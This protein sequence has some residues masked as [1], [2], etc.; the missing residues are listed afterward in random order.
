MTKRTLT[1]LGAVAAVSPSV[2]R[3]LA[4]VLLAFALGDSL[5]ACPL[6]LSSRPLT[7]SAQELAYAGRSV[8]AMP[9][10]EGK[11]FRVVEVIKGERP[12]GDVIVDAVFR[13]KKAAIASTK[14]LL[15]I[16]DDSW[17]RWVNFG[18][19]SADQVGWLRQLATTKRTTQ[20]DESEWR[21]HVAFFLPYL[22]NPEPMVAEIA[23]AELRNAPYAALR[24]LKPRLDIAAIR[25]WLGDPKLIPRRPL[26]TLLLGIGGGPEDAERVEQH[27]LAAHNTK[28]ATNLA[29]LLAAD[30]EL[31][32]PSRVAWIE[33]A[34]LLRNRQ[35]A[36]PEIEAALL[37]LSEQG[38][39][40]A[41]IPRERVVQ[42]Y[43]LFIRE[44]KTQAGLVAKDLA[45]WDCWDFSS[46]F[47]ALLRSGIPIR[48][49]SRAAII[50]YLRRNPK[51][52]PALVAELTTADPK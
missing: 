42:A 34:Y 46:E 9:T 41:N 19:I 5:R 24:S 29:P 12:S 52:E 22:E 32:G 36:L 33:E 18:P 45:D 43:R 17:A 6:C 14:P 37:A 35:R 20:I 11:S 27:L 39:V 7:I 40:N 4:A 30:L 23:H 16:R 50:D 48:D 13:G 8:L 44:H 10:A 49:T 1:C 31:R 38:K 51:T 47:C 25:Q 28:D 2:L 3:S 21:E 26:Y 15:L